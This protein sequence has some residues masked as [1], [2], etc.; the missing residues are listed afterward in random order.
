VRIA[1]LTSLG[2]GPRFAEP[3]RTGFPGAGSYMGA[4]SA[5]GL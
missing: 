5:I 3:A 1:D 4:K 2:F